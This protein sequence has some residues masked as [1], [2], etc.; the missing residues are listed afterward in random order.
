[1]VHLT[2]EAQF[3]KDSYSFNVAG[4]SGYD[5]LS[6]WQDILFFRGVSKF[7]LWRIGPDGESQL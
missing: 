1:M 4:L 6:K 3:P 7:C 2:H 5:I